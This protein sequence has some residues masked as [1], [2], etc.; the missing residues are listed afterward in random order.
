MTKKSKVVP[1][2]AMKAYEGA[3]VMYIP[4]IL[5]THCHDS[6]TQLLINSS[7]DMVK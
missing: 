3:S 1:V 7:E 2:N 5:T 4:E 6:G